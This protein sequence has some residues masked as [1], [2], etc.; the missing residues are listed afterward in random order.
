MLAKKPEGLTI[1]DE[2]FGT[3]MH[4]AIAGGEHG[5]IQVFLGKHHASLKELVGPYGNGLQMMLAW[6]TKGSFDLISGAEE[7]DKGST[8]LD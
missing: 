1:V 8:P 2:A 4:A 5:P 3:P 7:L 6:L